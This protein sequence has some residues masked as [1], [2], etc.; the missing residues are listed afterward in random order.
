MI[1][2]FLLKHLKKVRERKKS[3]EAAHNLFTFFG[4][5]GNLKVSYDVVKVRDWNKK[6]Y[7]Y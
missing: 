7:F 6:C 2:F 1:D 4:T 5:N 3:E